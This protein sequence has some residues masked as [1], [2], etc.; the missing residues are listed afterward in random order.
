MH[1]IIFVTYSFYL[2][3]FSTLEK[4]KSQIWDPGERICC[5]LSKCIWDFRKLSSREIIDYD[6]H[7]MNIDSDV[8][9]QTCGVRI[10]WS[11][12]CTNHKKYISFVSFEDLHFYTLVQRMDLIPLMNCMV[13]IIVISNERSRKFIAYLLYN[14]LLVNNV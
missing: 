14:L 10:T 9:S 7:Q 13:L 4:T 11:S 5:N 2:V 8:Y 12:A 3:L 1:I 6:T